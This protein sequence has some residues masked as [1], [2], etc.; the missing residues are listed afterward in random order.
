MPR[1]PFS[2]IWMPRQD[3][4]IIWEV[5][6]RKLSTGAAGTL[7][8]SL[9]FS[10]ALNNQSTSETVQTSA[11]TL[12]TTGLTANVPRI[13]QRGST[14][15][16]RG[17]VLE[18]QTSQ[19][20]AE[21]G[22]SPATGTGNFASTSTNVPVVTTGQ[23]GPDGQSNAS[24]VQM[25]TGSNAYYTNTVSTNL[26]SVWAKAASGTD[27]L[28]CGHLSNTAFNFNV[29]T[30]W[31]RY[32][33]GAPTEAGTSTVWYHRGTSV[34]T[35]S[36]NTNRDLY[37]DWRAARG[38]TAY[39]FHVECVTNGATKAAERL[40]LASASALL[41]SSRLGLYLML[42][43]KGASS[44]YVTN[45]MKVWWQDAS[46]YCEISSSTK[47]IN[48]VINGSSFSPATAMSWNRYDT[49]EIWIEG[50]GASLV[51]TIK[52][53]TT[54]FGSSTPNATINLGSSGSAQANLATTGLNF[55]SEGSTVIN[56]FTSWLQYVAA[57]KIGRKPAWAV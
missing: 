51:S 43:P 3:T 31:Q 14:S 7:P 22:F 6:F 11:N 33:W 19:A 23:T 42:I 55:L 52:Y 39:K 17:I 9:Q 34:I 27:V 35:P 50:G 37:L 20:Y 8:N 15:D 48:L 38:D 25:L 24:H 32:E 10:R 21:H 45:P 4:G 1:A 57:Y 12:L 18:H 29:D 47:R 28:T 16:S 13:G 2:R 53:R 36:A 5:D 44:E 41:D 30:N 49:L 46:N 26:S 54:P 56:V 40:Y